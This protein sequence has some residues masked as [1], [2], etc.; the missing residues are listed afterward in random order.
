MCA[1]QP[2]A[3]QVVVEGRISPGGCVVTAYTIT[4]EF[5]CVSIVK[6]VT[7]NTFSWCS[8]QLPAAMAGLAGG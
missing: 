4:P 1:G 5:S 7:G 3:R 8:L 2:E 6:A